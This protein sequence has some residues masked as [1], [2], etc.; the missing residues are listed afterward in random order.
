VQLFTWGGAQ[1]GY[2]T[3]PQAGDAAAQVRAQFT[4]HVLVAQTQFHAVSRFKERALSLGLAAMKKPAGLDAR[5][6]K[7]R[8]NS[9][10][11]DQRL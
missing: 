6:V 10:E 11:M 5:R 3:Q 9:S 4:N 2:A 1:D 8:S 7:L